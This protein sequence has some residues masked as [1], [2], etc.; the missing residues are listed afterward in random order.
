MTYEN[1]DAVYALNSYTWKLLE[2]NLG[3]EKWKELP[4]IIPV[5][6]QPE[7]LQSG[8]AFLVYG[9]ARH[10]AEHLY[11]LVKEAVSYT[12]YATSSTE[13]NKIANLLA[14]TFERQ[15]EAAD[16]V[17]SW[18]VTEDPHRSSPRGISFGSIRTM[19]VEK[20]TPADEE[21]GY[22]AGLVML[23]MKYTKQN[24][25]IQTSGFTY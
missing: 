22:V 2:A 14:D 8:K 20:A 9:S 5:A 25:T 21:G 16:D 3:W 4:P 13:V 7:L 12:I 15:D 1:K 23:E 17:N 11:A 18:L 6:Q 24:N 19:M 10:P